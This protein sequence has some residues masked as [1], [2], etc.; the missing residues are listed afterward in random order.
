MNSNIHQGLPQGPPTRVAK[1]RE[2]FGHGLVLVPT[3]WGT[4]IP[5]Q[6]GYT[7]F[8]QEKMSDP[9]HI[10]LLENN[11]IAILTGPKSGDLVSIDFDDD[12]AFEQF[13]T[14]NPQLCSTVTSRASRGCNLWYRLKGEYPEG[15]S[16]LINESE[17]EIGEWRAGRGITIVDGQHPEGVTYQIFSSDPLLEAPF[18]DIQWPE[19]WVKVPG[20]VDPF[21]DLVGEFGPPVLEGKQ[22][23]LQL[24]ESFVAG[25][26]ATEREILYALETQQF[27]HYEEPE[28]IW[29]VMP[30]QVV[31][32][33]IADYLGRLAR[34]NDIDTVHFKKKAT[35][36]NSV[37]GQL[38][39]EV[40]CEF[41]RAITPQGWR[42]FAA[43]NTKVA[44]ILPSDEMQAEICELP[45]SPGD[46]LIAKSRANYEVNATCPRF[47]NEV[48]APF[49]EPDDIR[50]LQKMFGL[51]LAGDNEL[52]KILLL[53]GPGG[54]SKGVVT[55]VLDQILGS[56]LVT[57]LRTDHLGS[58][59]ETSRY[60]GKRLLAGRDVDPDFLRSSS[61]TRLKALT[62]GDRLS[63][64][65]KN[66][67]EFEDIEG[68]FH[69]IITS[70]SPLL[71]RVDE[72]ASA[73]KRR[74]VIVPFHD[75]GQPFKIIQKFE[76]ELI[77]EEGP[78]ILKW[79]LDGAL[80]AFSDIDRY[81]TIALTPHQEAR[82]DARVRASDSVAFFADECLVPHNEREMSSQQLLDAYSG[83]CESLGLHAV[84]QAEFYRKMKSIIE[85]RFGDSVRYTENVQGD[86]GR[87]R[88]YRGLAL[89]SR[90]SEEPQQHG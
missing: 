1:I 80:L 49:L 63:T 54:T 5:I 28:G 26:I 14:C 34:E 64:E 68:V 43:S 84:T 13:R 23:G 73:W 88:G 24:N 52:Q 16:K 44:L 46:R 48:L 39:A 83:F 56:K 71:L 11:N 32:K 27:L 74:L 89:K 22:G 19:G 4:K 86:G 76:E 82:V 70:N 45:F 47:R 67:N 75:S 21:N 81:G 79:M 51:V 30:N 58:R 3:K 62:G 2:I 9:Q 17:E 90:S 60:R 57:E 55:R 8:G 40:A 77:R 50:L 36:I 33:L 41:Y 61:A 35:V 37:R 20:R 42:S 25:W 72:D 18:G 87:G 29:K 38:E 10:E 31:N 85:S 65:S 53:E 7:E 78:G 6:K 12:A 69:V 66:S 15:V 59:F